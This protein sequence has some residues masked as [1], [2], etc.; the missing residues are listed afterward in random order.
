MGLDTIELVMAIEEEFAIHIRDED[1]ERLTTPQ[2]VANY[3]MERVRHPG[4]SCPPQAGFY[5]LRSALIDAFSIPRSEIHPETRFSDLL[6]GDIKLQWK[7]LGATLGTDLP[8]LERSAR[9]TTMVFAGP[10]VIVAA[11]SSLSLPLIVLLATYIA[12]VFI[13]LRATIAARATIPSRYSTVEGLIP[14]VG[15][16][17][18]RKW[19]DETVLARVIELTSEQLG[20]P[21]DNIHPHSRFVQ[22]LNAD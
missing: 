12:I 7:E 1:A 13:A 2:K 14:F 16:S 6:R 21:I 10:A 22:D 19:T 8:A 17:S 9:L 18:S 3:V 5:R 4:M 11:L 15:C 20:V